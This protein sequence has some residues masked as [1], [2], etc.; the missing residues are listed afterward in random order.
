MVFARQGFNPAVT[1]CMNLDRTRGAVGASRASY[2]D[3]QGRR[4]EADSETLRRI[5]EAL[6]ARR[7]SAGRRRRRTG[8]PEPAYQGDGRKMLGA[9]GAALRGAIAAQ[10]GPRRFQRSRAICWK[11]SRISAAR[12]SGSTRCTRSSMTVRAAP[13]ARIRRTADCFSIRSISTSRRSRNSI[14][15]M[16]PTCRRD[17]RLREAE[18]VDYPAV[19]TVKIAALRAAYRNFCDGGSGRAAHDFAC[20]SGGARPR[21]RTFRRLRDVAATASRRVAGVARA[22]AAAGR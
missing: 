8:S 12:A 1:S 11:L 13:A 21:A 20:L 5:V 9:G 17:R 4:Q 2:F 19:A 6:S 15:A 7:Q 14:A 18:L 3:V 10:L 22:M 16:P